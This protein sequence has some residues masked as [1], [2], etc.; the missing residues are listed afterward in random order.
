MHYIPFSFWNSHSI[1]LRYNFS[2][3]FNFILSNTL[4][5]LNLN[6]SHFGWYDIDTEV[7]ILYKLMNREE[8][9]VAN[10]FVRLEKG[11]WIALENKRQK[12]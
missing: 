11:S 3:I 4:K 2:I 8:T 1:E 7:K 12:N 9:T 5:K 6:L 10:D